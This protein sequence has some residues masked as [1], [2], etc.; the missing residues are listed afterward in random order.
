MSRVV[1]P[2]TGEGTGRAGP[3][4]YGIAL[5]SGG[6]LLVAADDDVQ[7]FDAQGALVASFEGGAGNAEFFAL[8]LDPD[9]TSF[10][11]TDIENSIVHR[12][13]LTS[14]QILVS[15]PTGGPPKSGSVTSANGVI[16][17]PDLGLAQSAFRPPTDQVVVRAEDQ[18]TV[19]G[20]SDGSQGGGHAS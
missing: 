2:L 16:V 5:L 7:R 17:V 1:S 6:G 4:R 10:W 19:E 18:A 15:F 13:S 14:G 8:G 9:G 20:G 12:F 11:V 3:G